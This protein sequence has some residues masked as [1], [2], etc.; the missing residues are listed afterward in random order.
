[1]FY[2][3]DEGFARSYWRAARD[4]FILKFPIPPWR[5]AEMHTLTELQDRIIYG[6]LI[7]A[8]DDFQLLQ[9]PIEEVYDI[10]VGTSY[11][12]GGKTGSS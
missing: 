1:M 11:G 4:N 12:G 5:F 3:K 8:G 2:V 9:K 10:L 7:G 6:K